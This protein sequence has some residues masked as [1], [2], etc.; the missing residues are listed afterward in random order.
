MKPA[1]IDLHIEELVL[2]GFE[3][4]DRHGIALAVERELTR[5][6]AERGVPPSFSDGMTLGRID[7]G[8]FNVAPNPTPGGV[9]EQ[10][11][12]ALYGG[13]SR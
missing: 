13:L 9:G 10:V 2:H 11:G 8:A 3:P 1:V 7:A 12:Q 6:L 4:G 5:L